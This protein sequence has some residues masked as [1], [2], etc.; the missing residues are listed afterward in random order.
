ME[1]IFLIEDEKK[2]VSFLLKGLSECGYVVT[3]AEDGFSAI[4]MFNTHSFDV[5]LLAMMLPDMSGID[6]CRQIRKVNE[7]IPV[8]ML[9]AQ[10]NVDCKIQ[11]LRAGADDCLVRPFNFNELLARIEALLRRSRRKCVDKESLAFASLKLDTSSKT[12]ERD[13]VRIAL[14]PKEYKLLELF[15][16]YPNKTVSRK[17]IAEKV[18]DIEFDTGTNF[19]D[20]YVNY[21]R[22]KIDKGFKNKLIHTVIGMGYILKED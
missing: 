8:I 15:M 4:E 7:D 19:I 10:D 22:K 5:I 16:T 14:T 9:T 6:L 21:L 12:A 18:W 3:V 11:G 20:V 13:G 2:A 1:H 17:F